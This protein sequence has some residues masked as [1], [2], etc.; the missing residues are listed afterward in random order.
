MKNGE[1]PQPNKNKIFSYYDS[2]DK[3]QHEEDD[4][5]RYAGKH[6]GLRADR[7]L[8]CRERRLHTSKEE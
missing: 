2:L 6:Y 7:T 1:Q 3:N 4:A 5:A 8:Y